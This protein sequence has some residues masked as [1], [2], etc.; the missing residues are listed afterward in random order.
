MNP[1]RF[2][3]NTILASALALG[4]SS[5]AK[6]D[7]PRP[8]IENLPITC[9]MIAPREIIR[10]EN[11]PTTDGGFIERVY[12]T[13]LD[14]DATRLTVSRSDDP[15]VRPGDEYRVPLGQEDLV[16]IVTETEKRAFGTPETDARFRTRLST[17]RTERDLVP[18]GKDFLIYG[19]E[20]PQDGRA[21]TFTYW[22]A[23]R[24]F[25][26]ST[27]DAKDGHSVAFPI[28]VEPVTYAAVDRST[29]MPAS[30]TT[31]AVRDAE[32][33]GTPM[34]V[35]IITPP[36]SS[37][38]DTYDRVVVPVQES[39]ILGRKGADQYTFH[40]SRGSQYAPLDF[41]ITQLAVRYRYM[42][43]RTKL[44]A[45]GAFTSGDD[46]AG[47]KL[48]A[49]DAKLHV[50]RKL[51]GK[52][53]ALG[54]SA[55]VGYKDVRTYVDA[56][57]GYALEDS[58]QANGYGYF[59]VN[60]AFTG[61]DGFASGNWLV[62]RAGAVAQPIIDKHAPSGNGAYAS[63]TD[64]EVAPEISADVRWTPTGRTWFDLQG[65]YGLDVKTAY[66]SPDTDRELTRTS[67][68]KNLTLGVG[69]LF[70]DAKRHGLYG[71]LK[72]ADNR[73][74]WTGLRD[75]LGRTYDGN[76]L[77]EGLAVGLGYTFRWK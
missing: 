24:C 5:I 15:A 41:D 8:N 77:H 76:G 52:N 44:D 16:E 34:G 40:D 11:I 74:T 56:A 12:T 75:T 30:P 2:L 33:N 37:D 53:A 25:D 42:G 55:A 62:L 54:I 48:S 9:S 26:P 71:Q 70:G 50:D 57:P 35:R 36:Q 10:H 73:E 45:Q 4:L 59:G 65:R 72:W 13:F 32:R 61:D 63:T 58:R 38:A 21:R 7:E 20:L 1:R 18:I 69:H 64:L 17:S 46:G 23:S 27:G 43:E 6:A 49:R 66:A 28:T 60:L 68:Y 39:T 19:D 67:D 3:R 22:T 47:L 51:I 31:E 14:G 29:L